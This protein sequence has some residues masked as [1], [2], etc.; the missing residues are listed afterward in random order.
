[1]GGYTGQGTVLHVNGNSF[2]LALPTGSF[3]EPGA[4]LELEISRGDDALYLLNACVL[5]EEAQGVY[6]MGETGEPRRLQRRRFRR[7]TLS[8]RVQYLPREKGEGQKTGQG[9]FQNISNGGALLRTEEPLPPGSEY[10][11]VFDLPL[12]RDKTVTTR[13]GGRVVRQ[14]PERDGSGYC[15][16]IKFDWFL[17]LL[18]A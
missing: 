12:G 18:S 11:L 5:R 2:A 16:G 6:S 1:M 13:V 9:F 15:S 7:I 3:L 10:W 4:E 17:S 14:Q 8:L